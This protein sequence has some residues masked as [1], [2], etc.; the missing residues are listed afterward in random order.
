MSTISIKS[1]VVNPQA[2]LKRTISADDF[3][4]LKLHHREREKWNNE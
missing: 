2:K 1:T 4:A 3:D